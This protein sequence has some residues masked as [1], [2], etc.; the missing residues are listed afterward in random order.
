MVIATISK[1]YLFQIF[2]SRPHILFYKLFASLIKVFY[3]IKQMGKGGSK[4]K[5]VNLKSGKKN[6]RGNR[7][8]QKDN[9]PLPQPPAQ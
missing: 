2:F 4:V 7:K 3:N 5:R 9:A 6:G 1:C 8:K